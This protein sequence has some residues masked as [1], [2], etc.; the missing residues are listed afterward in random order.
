[1]LYSVE[2][3]C[4]PSITQ[5]VYY[6]MSE[7]LQRAHWV[8]DIIHDSRVLFTLKHD[9]YEGTA[10][11]VDKVKE[12]QLAAEVSKIMTTKELDGLIVELKHN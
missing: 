12:P 3:S 10:R 8:Q 6:I 11:I 7:L 9:T 4:R 5:Q 1:M 2:Y